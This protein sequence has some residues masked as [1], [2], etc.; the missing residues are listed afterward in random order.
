MNSPDR[1]TQLGQIF[2]A[3]NHGN[4]PL[5]NQLIHVFLEQHPNDLEGIFTKGVIFSALGNYEDAIQVFEAILVVDPGNKTVHFYKGNCLFSLN[6]YR[7]A[8]RSYELVLDIDQNHFNCLL[9]KGDTHF[10]LGEFNAALACF[11]D[12]LK[13]NSKDANL[14]NNIAAT[15]HELRQH[16]AACQQF[17][18]LLEIEPNHANAWANM[19]NTLV[20]MGDLHEAIKAY[21]SAIKINPNFAGAYFNKANVL[22]QLKLFQ[23]AL[24]NYQK[25][26]AID[27]NYPFLKGSI[28]HTSMQICDWTDFDIRINDISKNIR[29][30][31][32]AITHPFHALS[33]LSDESLHLLSASYWVARK[34]KQAN[35]NIKPNITSNKKIKLGYFSADFYDHAV[36]CLI[37]EVIKLHDREKF[38]VIGFFY[39]RPPKD[40]MHERLSTTFDKFI[41]IDGLS[42]QQAARLANELNIDIT[43]DL[44]GLTKNG[45]PG[46]FSNRAAAIQVNYLGYPGTIGANFYDYLIADQHLI[47]PSNRKFFIE[48]IAYVPNTYQANDTSQKD[49]QLV[50]SRIEHGLPLSGFIFCCFNN[51]YKITPLLFK[52]WMEILKEIDNSVLWLLEDNA[53]AKLNLQKHAADYGVDPLRLI[54]APKIP[55]MEHLARHKLADLFLDTLPY[56]AHTTASDS[57]WAGLPLL[58][59]TGSSFAGK[60]ATSLLSALDAPELISAN[61]FD[62]KNKAIELA[63]NPQLLSGIK[64]KIALNKAEKPLFN[65]IQ[66]TKDIERLYAEM[67]H[68][69]RNQIPP[70]NIIINA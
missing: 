45:R 43:I 20:E 23:D 7:E 44:T 4:L 64:R 5:S 14:L 21:D 68:R 60:V 15:L 34:I 58:T 25:A 6:L 17:K 59:C 47:P 50:T 13:I 55:R 67:V 57:L 1:A 38:E 56:N 62:Y 40:S 32:N 10:V 28:L 19:G 26:S 9:N 39:G 16:K 2:N 48:K 24:I 27:E 53:Y 37:A 36:S 46:I 42:D 11:N 49:S 18:S 35:S 51:N 30:N 65:S 52:I 69:I 54:F 70:D 33:F 41:D 66:F 12:A 31:K 61:L 22:F 8:I 63:N 29:T 3:F